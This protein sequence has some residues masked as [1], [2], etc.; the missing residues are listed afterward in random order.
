MTLLFKS[1]IV[2][3]SFCLLAL[4]ASA[5]DLLVPPAL[6]SEKQVSFQELREAA[7]ASQVIPSEISPSDRQ[8]WQSEGKSVLIWI[9]STPEN[10]LNLLEGVIRIHQLNDIKI[11]NDAVYYAEKINLIIL[12]A[13]QE[14]SLSRVEERGIIDL[15]RAV[16]ILSGDY[17]DG[18]KKI[19]VVQDYL[20]DKVFL[21]Y[22]KNYPSQYRKLQKD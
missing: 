14:G 12:Q 18:R 2:A 10:N 6:E 4:T 22:K 5:A 19:E 11:E 9:A 15:F 20:G 13:M 1:G 16:A 21:E 17:G 3:L 7:A 8:Y